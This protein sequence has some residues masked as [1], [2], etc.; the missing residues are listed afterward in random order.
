M[1][2]NRPVTAACNFNARH[3]MCL[4]KKRYETKEMATAKMKQR[5]AS[6]TQTPEHLKVYRC[7]VCR[8][9]HLTKQKR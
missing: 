8:G 4:K 6:D 1:H 7:L 9:W 2:W 5:L 3:C